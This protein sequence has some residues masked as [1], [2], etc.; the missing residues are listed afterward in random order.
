MFKQIGARKALKRVALYGA[1]TLVVLYAIELIYLRFF[2]TLDLSPL[3]EILF[4]ALTELINQ[5]TGRGSNLAL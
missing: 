5:L 4:S 1:V 3:L 2:W